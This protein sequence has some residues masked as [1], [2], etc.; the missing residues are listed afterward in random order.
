V[1]IEF[2]NQP[3]VPANRIVVRSPI[4]R[5]PPPS[6]RKVLA[7]WCAVT[8]PIVAFYYWTV[9][10]S[11]G[12]FVFR[13]DA[14]DHYNLL[15][16]G[17]LHGH[18]YLAQ[19]PA[20]EMLALPDP[21]D[22]I[23]NGPWRLHDAS[24]YHGHY[25]LYFGP[26]PVITLFLPCKIL[27]GGN[28]SPNFA[29]FVYGVLGYG[30]SCLLLW[31][32]LVATRARPGLALSAVAFAG[33]SLAQF[34]PIVMRRPYMYEVAIT[35]SFCFLMGG[36]AFLAQAALVE[37]KRL[38]IWTPLAGIFLGLVPGCRPHLSLAVAALVIWY[39]VFL[40]KERKLPAR[41]WLMEMVRFCL[42]IALC[43][44]AL[45]WY[46]SARFDSTF[47]FGE[48]YQLTAARTD[49]GVHLGLKNV[50]LGFEGLLF[51]PPVKLDRFPF[52]RLRMLHNWEPTIGSVMLMPL[53]AIGCGVAAFSL[54]RWRRAE[55][56]ATALA[57]AGLITLGFLSLKGDSNARYQLD[58]TPVLWVLALFSL[59]RLA[60]REQRTWVRR[61]TATLIVAG[62][63]W[64]AGL[65]MLLSIEGYDYGLQRM[66]PELFQQIASWFGRGS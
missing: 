42:P 15:T 25:Y 49:V 32:L 3:A 8:I 22:P 56:F 9:T 33:L 7:A 27:L 24:L 65:S 53:C 60:V 14:V 29:V 11:A 50:P 19:D 64:A 66:N 20:P 6:R 57:M 4:I 39:A 12:P 41:R 16:D 17:F 18:L 23:A 45:A 43:G 26:T 44:A 31:R 28:A 61:A 46:N 38:P 13:N 55:W 1:P 34:T 5:R 37:R 35:A 36:L 58:Y 21:H 30:F 62:C 40:A 2:E 63:S 54:R 51:C 52:V 48:S 47:E 10:S 59:I